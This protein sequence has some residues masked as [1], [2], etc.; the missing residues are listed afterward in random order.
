MP[1]TT[2]KPGVSPSTPGGLRQPVRTIRAKRT[3][4]WLQEYRAEN[5]RG[6]VPTWGQRAK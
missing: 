2:I 4:L 1:T 6:Y 3:P 5:G